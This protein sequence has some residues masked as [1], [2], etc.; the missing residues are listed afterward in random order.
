MTGKP[1]RFL[2]L[3]DSYTI[4]EGVP[5]DARWPFIVA[6][7]LRASG[8]VIDDPDIVAVTGWTTDELAAGMD[9]AAL[10]P[11]YDLVTLLIGVNNQYRGRDL[12]NYR[13]EFAALL[14]RA[15]ALTGG[16]ARHVLGVSIPDWGVTRF[17]KTENRD[18]V[19]IGVE[20]D[21]FNTAAQQMVEAARGAWVNIT[22]V[23]RQCAD[24]PDMLADDGLHPSAMQYMLWAERIMPVARTVLT[25]RT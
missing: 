2:A 23:S 6:Q 21:A 9:Q 24:A 4:G 15:I 20:L 1:L 7:Q 19:R 17:A 5:A 18:S 3:G 10:E 12:A 25:R 14:A 11:S 13:E 8:I 22:P 16:D